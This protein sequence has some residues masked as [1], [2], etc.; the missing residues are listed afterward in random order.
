MKTAIL[1]GAT[2]LTGG[3]LLQKLLN[4]PQYGKIILFSR[5]SVKIKNSKIEEH[6]VDLFQLEKYKE[7]FKADQVFCCIGTTKSKTPSEETY[8]KIDYGIPV[9]AAKLCKENGIS[10]LAV[11]SSLGANPDSGMFYNKIKGEMQRDVLAQKITNTFIFQPSLISGDRGEKR[12]FENLGKQALKILNH[13]LLGPLE[14]YRSIHPLIIAKAMLIVANK[15]YEKSVIES[16]EIKKIA[17][18]GN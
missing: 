12:F 1:L 4:D 10:T 7:Q 3:I 9:T 14:K 18:K 11:I 6:L 16:D 15:G 17:A 2:G 5:S 13:A 8:R